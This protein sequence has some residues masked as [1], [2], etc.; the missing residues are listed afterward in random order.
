MIK[1]G[2]RTQMNSKNPNTRGNMG[3]LEGVTGI[4]GIR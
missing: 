2:E 3:D 1:P 4:K